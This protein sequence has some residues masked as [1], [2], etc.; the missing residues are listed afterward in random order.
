MGDLKSF[1]ASYM[2]GLKH[3]IK[4][5]IAAA[6]SLYLAKFMKMPEGY[7]AAITAIIV[8]QSNVGLR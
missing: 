6:A 7:W 8:M 4:T 5:A 2:P 3:A 1:A